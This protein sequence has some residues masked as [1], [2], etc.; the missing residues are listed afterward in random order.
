VAER[1]REREKREGEW[2]MSF[3]PPSRGGGVVGVSSS[4]R[5]LGEVRV[6]VTVILGSA[7]DVRMMEQFSMEPFTSYFS[8]VTT[9]RGEE[10]ER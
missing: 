2:A 9:W 1:E 7:S 8:G 5:M 6:T 4:S 3:Q 10:R